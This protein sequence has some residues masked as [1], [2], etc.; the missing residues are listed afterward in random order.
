MSSRG[1]VHM[2]VFFGGSRER[3]F[4][5]LFTVRKGIFPYKTQRSA[6]VAAMEA[7]SSQRRAR[8][9]SH[10]LKPLGNGSKTSPEPAEPA[11]GTIGKVLDP[12]RDS[13]T[14]HM[15]AKHVW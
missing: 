13:K 15:E 9:R 6:E 8:I 2:R 11:L 4:Q 10:E 7:R 1:G 14:T 3:R 5:E 12:N